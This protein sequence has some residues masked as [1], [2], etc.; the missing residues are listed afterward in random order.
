MNN[1]A[2]TIFIHRF[3]MDDC[4]SKE[5]RHSWVIR[6][7]LPEPPGAQPLPPCAWEA[8]HK[9]KGNHL[10]GL[11]STGDQWL[12]FF[13]SLSPFWNENFYPKTTPPVCSG[14]NKFVFPRR[15]E[16]GV[17]KLIMPWASF[18]SDLHEFFI[19]G[20]FCKQINTFGVTR[21]KWI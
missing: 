14:S 10:V 7:T 21:M 4:F 20:L 12:I 15:Q 19:S 8:G 11:R 1:T 17:L 5:D 6:A 13:L 16:G 18:I 2:T 3:H 9:V